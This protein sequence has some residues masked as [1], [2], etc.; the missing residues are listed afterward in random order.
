MKIIAVIQARMSSTR[1][2][3]KVLMDICGKP[4]LWHIVNRARNSKVLKQVIIATSEEKE[5]DAIEEFSVKYEIPCY[6]G[7]QD[8]VLDRF[9]K[10]A[11]QY[12]PDIVVRLTGDNALIDAQVIDEALELFVQ[13]G[14][15]D[16][17]YYHENLPLGMAVEVMKMSALTIAHLEATDIECIEHVTPYL[18]KNAN[19]FSSKRVSFPELDYSNLRWTMDTE[20]DR[21]LIL[22]IYETLYNE[23]KFFGYQDILKEYKNHPE[24]YEMNLNIIQKEVEY[25]GENKKYEEG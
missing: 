18:Y 1:L 11:S 6:R 10:S 15:L 22:S 17:M 8:N 9:W 25:S 20:E 4:M 13:D 16:Y 7:S 5:D 21:K 2:P 14:T 23:D 12:N 19:M 3:K 24:W